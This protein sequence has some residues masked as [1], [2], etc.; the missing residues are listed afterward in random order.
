MPLLYDMTWEDVSQYLKKRDTILL[1]IGSTEQ[2]GYHL[3]LG[4]DSFLANQLAEDASKATGVISAPPIWYGWTPQH[5][6]LPGTATLK[7]ETLIQVV[8]D[9]AESFIIHGFKKILIINGHR[10][11]NLPPLRIAGSKI[12]NSTGAFVGIVDP[13]F[14]GETI[15]REIRTSEPGGVGHADELET[16]H[17]MYLFPELVD[18]TKAVK[19]ILPQGH[20][21]YTDP[22][23]EGDRLIVPSEYASNLKASKGIG[24]LSDPTV[25]SAE[26]GRMY[27]ERLVRDLVSAIA[28]VEEMEVLIRRI[29]DIQA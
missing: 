17:M 11:A 29:P 18:P 5:M 28:I 1:P 21:L 7:A 6:G 16:S 9:V 19:T 12:R 23:V 3:P 14:F 27:H 20:F 22:Y 4:T 24:V 25:S 2:H 8:V 26:K 10:D 13:F 15:G